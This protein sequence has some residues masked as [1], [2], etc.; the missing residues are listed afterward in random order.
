MHR[1]QAVIHLIS[2]ISFASLSS[3]QQSAFGFPAR[4]CSGRAVGSK[5]GSTSNCTVAARVS[6][7]DKKPGKRADLRRITD[8]RRQSRAWPTERRFRADRRL[9]NISVEW[10]PFDEVYS[11]PGT[12]DAFCS[13]GRKNSKTVHPPA[14]DA[15]KRG[16][17]GQTRCDKERS[18]KRPWRIDIFKRTQRSYVEQRTI[19]D[20][21]M[22]NIKLPYNRRVRPDRRLNNISLEWITYE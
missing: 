7:F 5:Q 9:N 14:K 17:S 10:I 21:R 11:H 19:T 2:V 12:R 3:L 1:Y 18:Q 8:R 13:I 22:K 6:S 16:L 20:R 4:R 15:R